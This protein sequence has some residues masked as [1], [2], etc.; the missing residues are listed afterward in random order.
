MSAGAERWIRVYRYLSRALP[1]DFLRLHGPE[2]LQ[3]SEDAIRDVARRRGATGLAVL[4]VRLVVDL[5]GRVP[6]EHTAELIHDVRYGWRSLWSSP[7]VVIASVL[8]VGLGIGIAVTVFNQLN[9][10]LAP[11]PG[12]GNGDTLVTLESPISLPELEAIG[13][14]GGP[15]SEVAGYI[16]PVPFVIDRGTEKTRIWGH[17]VTPEYFRVLRASLQLG[18]APTEAGEPGVI[19]SERYWK[20]HLGGRTDVIG[21]AMTVNGALARIDGVAGPKFHGPSPVVAAADL[22]VTTT[23]DPRIAPEL[24]PARL[25][26]LERRQFNVVGRL[27]PGWTTAAAQAT[28]DTMVRNLE[29]PS[30]I[31]AERPREER[32]VT[33]LSSRV[34][35]VRDSDLSVL[36]VLPGLLVGLTLWIACANVATLLLAR[37]MNRRRELAVR[38]AI[39]G[40]RRRVVKQ[41]VTESVLLALLGGVVGIVITWW[42]N[43]EAMKGI[44]MLPSYVHL[45]L[46]M[47]WMTFLFAFLVSLASGVLFGIVPAIQASRVDLT[48]WMKGAGVGRLPA[49]RWLGSRNLLVLQQ[50]AG[51]LMLIL[52]TGNVAVRMGNMPAML[53][54]LGFK[55]DGVHVFSLDPL[56]HGYDASAAVEFLEGM[57]NTLTQVPGIASAAVSLKDPL[58]SAIRFRTPSGQLSA[59][60]ASLAADHVGVG[61]F[62]TLQVKPVSGRVFRDGDLRDGDLRVVVNE[63]LARQAWPEKDPVGEV[64]ELENRRFEV[65]GVVPDFRDAGFLGRSRPTAF[66]LIGAE[67]LADPTIE[68]ITLMVRGEPGVDVRALVEAELRRR[69]KPVPAFNATTLDER[70]RNLTYLAQYSSVVYGAIGFFGLLLA[71]VGLAGVTAY[72][73]TR[74]TR[75]I[76]VRVALGASRWSVL[77]LVCR[78]GA[79][80]VLVGTVI[81]QLGAVA[82]LMALDAWFAQLSR[83]T[84]SRDVELIVAVGAP[85]LLAALTMMSCYLPARRSL[86]IEPLTALRQ[87]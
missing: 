14:S 47:D 61:Y 35:P 30:P 9:V 53:A 41:L 66:H 67:K 43:Y 86:R 83:V 44:A 78:E 49:F 12:V 2:M 7:G 37:A 29:S 10:M 62:E 31:G 36:I 39:G 46:A 57:P 5:I 59:Q 38:V 48:E 87:E 6:T 85:V 58:A 80:L 19:V 42:S 71:S 50:V 74:R 55:P 15:F 27:A 52:L 51:S 28:L 81:G 63:S 25:R 13:A 77:R 64:L 68:G 33:L 76:A 45:E 20:T 82:M 1:E 24:R 34:V 16:G 56:R 40:S 11:A 65:V 54:D 23:A 73:V 79:W 22:W 3:A 84:G 75:E 26:E 4:M 72:A 32:R 8:S 18:R 21:S 17:I 70:I 60:V 69:E